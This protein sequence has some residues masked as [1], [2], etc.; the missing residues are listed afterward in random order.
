MQAAPTCPLCAYPVLRHIRAGTIDWLCRYCH[1]EVP[2]LASVRGHLL[3][4]EEPDRGLLQPP[5]HS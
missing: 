3:L 1:Q 4:R 2:V 5:N